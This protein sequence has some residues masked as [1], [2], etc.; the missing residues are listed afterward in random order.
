M[1]YHLRQKKDCDREWTVG[2]G[3]KAKGY[4]LRAFRK[5]YPKDAGGYQVVGAIGAGC[6]REAGEWI[7][8]E[9]TEKY[10]ELPT[11]HFLHKTSGYIEVGENTYLAVRKSRIGERLVELFLIIAVISGIA[12]GIWYLFFGPEGPDIDP[13][14]G[15]YTADVELP[16]NIDPDRITL[17]GYEQIRM[18]AGK[19][20]A[21]VALWNPDRNPCYFQFEIVLDET[22]E[23]IY[24]SRLIPPG[25]A[26]TE[27]Q[28]DR[29]FDMGIYPI[30]IRINTFNLEDYE[31][32]MNGG[33]I[34]AELVA[35]EQE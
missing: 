24:Q 15:K 13:G 12:A 19:D 30:T 1:E 6:S 31:Q 27:V 25:N 2:G 10:Y 28:F 33:E 11:E 34:A 14:A 3:K 8:G 5:R 35:V 9:E 17:P 7:L 16:E 29:T 20:T 4:S 32:P 26:V 21:Y 18:E 22:G 23:T